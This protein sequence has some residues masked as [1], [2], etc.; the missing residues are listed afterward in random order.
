MCRTKTL[1]LGDQDMYRQ[2]AIFAADQA[3]RIVF[4]YGTPDSFD[5]L[6]C[7]DLAVL[8]PRHDVKPAPEPKPGTHWLAYLSIGEVLESCDWFRQMPAKW[9]V[10]QNK[11][12]NSWVIDQSTTDWPEFF[13]RHIA[14]S[15]QRYCP[16][17]FFLDTMDS[18]QLLDPQQY[19]PKHQR[20]GLVRAVTQLRARFPQAIIILNRGFEVLEQLHNTVDAVAFESLYQGWDQSLK[21][22]IEISP[23]DR[24]WLLMQ[25]AN[26]R[27]LGLATIAIDYCPEDDFA[28]SQNIASAIRQ[29]GVIPYVGDNYLQAINMHMLAAHADLGGKN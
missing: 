4:Y 11:D 18:W 17:G 7:F 29:H 20:N 24:S 14:Q 22:Y 16:D 19:P 15:A 10:K 3:P 9:L 26:A 5:D 2:G 25:A 8:E 27:A 6:D 23:Q 28:R 1:T 21:S 12:W 13:V